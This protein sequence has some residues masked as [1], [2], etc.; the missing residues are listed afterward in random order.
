MVKCGHFT[1]KYAPFGV[2]TSCTSFISST[3]PC[4]AIGMI[5]EDKKK[6]YVAQNLDNLKIDI[7]KGQGEYL[8]A[9]AC[10]SGCDQKTQ[11]ELAR[12]FQKNFTEIYGG[13]PEKEPRAIYESMEKVMKSDPVISS[14]CYVKS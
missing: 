7:A 12:L 14:G 1:I 10:L 11:N 2:L 6:L 13:G 5:Q 3:G 8:N 9:Y 4:S